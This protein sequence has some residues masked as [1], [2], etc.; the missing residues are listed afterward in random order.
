MILLQLI[1]YIIKKEFKNREFVISMFYEVALIAYI[2]DRVFGE[3]EDLKFFK[4][5]IILM[6]NYISWFQNKFYKDSIFRGILLTSSLLVIV[7]FISYILS[8]FDNLSFDVYQSYPSNYDL[9]VDNDYILNEDAIVENGIHSSDGTEIGIHG[10]TS[11]FTSI[12]SNPQIV[13]KEIATETDEEGKLAVKI[14]V[15]A[16]NK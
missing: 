14:K 12:P 6:G 9:P 2:I 11:P 16:Q 13:S 10:G 1:N 15:E 4:H 5:P 8:L 3:F 7:F